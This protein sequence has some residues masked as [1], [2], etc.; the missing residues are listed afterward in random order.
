M[1]KA[2]CKMQNRRKP[3]MYIG[4]LESAGTIQFSVMSN[5][6]DGRVGEAMEFEEGHGDGFA[7]VAA[8]EEDVGIVKK[9]FVD[10]GGHSVD[11]ADGGLA[12]EIEVGEM[13]A[14][15]GLVGEAQ[16]FRVELKPEPL[17]IDL[18]AGGQGAEYELAVGLDDDGLDEAGVRRVGLSGK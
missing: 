9:G 2:G 7:V 17:E 11:P 16:I 14:K 15:L 12:G 8:V 13:L 3:R 4:A 5:V 10:E 1:Q 18:I 6:G